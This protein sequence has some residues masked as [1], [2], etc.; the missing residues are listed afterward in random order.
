[1]KLSPEEIEAR[2]RELEARRAEKARR[3]RRRLLF[4]LAVAFLALVLAVATGYITYRRGVPLADLSALMDR[5]TPREER[6]RQERVTVL[7]LGVDDVPGSVP[8]SDVLMLVSFEPETGQ[9]GIISIPRDTRV[10]VP[11]RGYDRI[12]AALAYGGP[13]LAKRTVA[14]FLGVD[15]D[16]YVKV[17]FA[18]FE[19]FVDALG[20]VEMDIPF[21]MRYDDYAGGVHINLPAGRHRLNGQQALQYVRYR[22][23]LGDVSLVN[24]EQERY[25]GR[26]VR[27]LR[28]VQAL[29]KQAL[30][31]ESLPKLP[32]LAQELRQMVDTDMPWDRVLSLVGALS[33]VE[34]EKVATALVPGSGEVIGGASYWV[35][36]PRK[37]PE[38]VAE[39]LLGK[40]GG[41]QQI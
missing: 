28:F 38:V 2:Y 3:R 9:V 29:V 35:A 6:L 15:V 18:A 30:K 12:N 26:V 22:G 24:P 32:V 4:T 31:A 23:G 19:S 34:P 21:N 1:M 41:Q 37:T 17:D 8:R 39:V 16:Y 27:Q 36:D 11:G 7:V 25:D 10:Y 40:K 5:G 13:A 20:G 14:D 33:R